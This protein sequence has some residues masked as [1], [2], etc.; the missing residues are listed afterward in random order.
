M[1]DLDSWRDWWSHNGDR[2][3]RDVLMVWWDP[4]G[5]YGEPAAYD[6][7]DDVV[8][9]VGKRLRAGA[10]AR[11]VAACLAAAAD[12]M[13]AGGPGLDERAA[14]KVTEWYEQ[15][16]KQLERWQPAAE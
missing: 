11:E 6:E 10:D 12:R 7:Y 15:A 16:M 2:E 1:V 14:I 8:L 9:Q 4:I 3:L 13:E 5:V